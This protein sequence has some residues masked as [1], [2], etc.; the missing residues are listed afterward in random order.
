MK[1]IGIALAAALLLGATGAAHSQA[2]PYKPLRIIIPFGAGGAQDIVARSFNVELA[3]ALGQPVIVDNRPGAGGVVGTV[4]AA[5]ST[6]DGYTLLLAGVSHQINGF[7]YAKPPY[8]PLQDFTPLSYV[9]STGYV[10]L[11]PA[12]LPVKSVAELIR[13]AKSRP[14][15]LNYASAG[16]GSAIHL[17]MAYLASLAGIDMLHVPLKSGADVLIELIAARTQATTVPINVARPYAQ[18]QRLRMLAVTGPRRSKF[19]PHLPT[20]A[21]SG[22]PGYE[23]ESWLGLLGPAGMP[24]NAVERIDSE[25]ARL[26]QS[27]AILERL[28]RQGVESATLTSAQFAERLGKEQSRWADIVKRSGVKLN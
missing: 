5:K 14:G 23:F 22:I 10:L 7:L 12:A 9:G 11:V 21:E 25:M 8:N 16:V 2:Y 20:V 3:N 6:P 15:E 17:S 24:R 27:P 18:E 4:A 26:L 1:A 19:L 13:H 28:N